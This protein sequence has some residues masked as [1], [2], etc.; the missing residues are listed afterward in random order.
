MK[1]FIL[2]V[3]SS[4]GAIGIGKLIYNKG[5][6]DQ[7]RELKND[8]EQIQKGMMFG[9]QMKNEIKNNADEFLEKIRNKESE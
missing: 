9:E 5:R 8:F 4:F 1:K 6:R 3:V 7:A 2:G